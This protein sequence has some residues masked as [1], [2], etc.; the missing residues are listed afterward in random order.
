MM[1]LTN[2]IESPFAPPARR[3]AHVACRNV[4]PRVAQHV[5]IR[6]L[7]QE[8]RRGYRDAKQLPSGNPQAPRV[9]MARIGSGPPAQGRRAAYFAAVSTISLDGRSRHPAGRWLGI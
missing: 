4:S 6:V 2:M 1:S 8:S 5:A 9:A 7:H 3:T